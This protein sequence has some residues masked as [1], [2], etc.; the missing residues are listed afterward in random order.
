M[1]RWFA[2][3]S[4]RVPDRTDQTVSCKALLNYRDSG[5]G[6][7]GRS[8]VVVIQCRWVTFMMRAYVAVDGRQDELLEEL[9]H[10]GARIIEHVDRLVLTQN[11]PKHAAWASNCWYGPERISVA[12][13]REATEALI[14]KAPRWCL[15]SQ[16]HHRRAALI[17]AGLR[18]PDPS[19]LRFGEALPREPLGSWTLLDEHTILASADCAS[20]F[21]HGEIEFIE[22]KHAPPSR[23]YLKLWEAFTV[24]RRKPRKGE[25]CLDLGSSPGGWTWVLASLGAKVKS[26]DKSPLEPR[27]AGM[28]G[29][30]FEQGSAF[31]IDP[32]AHAPVDWLFSDVICYPERLYEYVQRW[33]DAGKAK[34]FV[35]TLK[36]QGATDH[37]TARRFAKIPG[38]RLMHLH[39]N[40]HELTW[41]HFGT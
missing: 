5:A 30:H 19:P 14:A 1:K 38:S 32:A 24:T 28:P 13:I 36:F 26:V 15:L 2:V 25:S 16:N 6:A 37:E 9:R 40:R 12:S 23:A 11:G 27:I 41:C 17:Q 4:W 8:T 3:S 31:S 20:P 22:D 18:G 35:C 33:L 7:D 21:P 29:V 10:S 34:H 39:H